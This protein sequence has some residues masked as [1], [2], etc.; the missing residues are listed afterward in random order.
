MEEPGVI[1]L[2][3]RPSSARKIPTNGSFKRPSSAKSVRSKASSSGSSEDS[4]SQKVWNPDAEVCLKTYY[5]CS[6]FT[7]LIVLFTMIVSFVSPGWETVCYDR[8]YLLFLAAQY[9]EFEV[10]YLN[11]PNHLLNSNSSSCH[12]DMW[13]LCT[14]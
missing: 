9:G 5:A 7:S 10:S 6:L 3:D 13:D 11:L 14:S 8:D 2:K 12:F 1:F 4:Q